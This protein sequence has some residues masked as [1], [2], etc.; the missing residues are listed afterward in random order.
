MTVSTNYKVEHSQQPL[1]RPIFPSSFPRE[2]IHAILAHLSHKDVLQ[3]SL[4]SK[5]I[6]IL[7]K[8]KDLWDKLLSRDFNH[9]SDL[10]SYVTTFGRNPMG[11]YQQLTIT[12]W[13][14][15]NTIQAETKKSFI[16]KC[17]S[18]LSNLKFWK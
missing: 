13:E 1:T 10:L 8:D 16:K 14:P 5:E 17:T 7:T 9:F 12:C 15:H 6:H 2:L 4:V 3:C 18:A 11:L